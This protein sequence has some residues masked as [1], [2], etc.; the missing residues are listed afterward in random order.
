MKEVSLIING[1]GKSQVLTLS[2]SSTVSSVLTSNFALF[3]STVDCFV[4]V[5]ATAVANTDIFIPANMYCRLGVIAGQTLAV[6]GTAAGTAY[7]T[8]ED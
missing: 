3:Y 7:L 8:S 4:R 5:G 2:T 1:G 6:V